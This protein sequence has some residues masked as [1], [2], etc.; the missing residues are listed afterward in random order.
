MTL[1]EKKQALAEKEWVQFQLVHNEGGRASCQ[2][3]PETFF[4]MRRSQ[5]SA[6]PEDLTDCYGRDLQNAEEEGRNLLAEKYAWMMKS[7]APEQFQR[8]SHLLPLPSEQQER[9]IGLIA[10]IE[11]LWMEEYGEKYPALASGNRPVHSSEDSQYETSFE[12]YLKG[13][14]HTYSENTLLLYLDFVRK[15]KAEGKN[16]AILTM[17]AMVKGYGYQSLEAAEKQHRQSK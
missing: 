16:L 8:I 2:E 10:E 11:V 9:L 1:E 5:F 17:E 14:L 4:L 15:L 6:W 13:E 3:D 12:T 7:T